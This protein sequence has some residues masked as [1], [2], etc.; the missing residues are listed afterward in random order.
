MRYAIFAYCLLPTAY[1]LLP[2]AYC[3]L[4][5]AYRLLLT[6][7]LAHHR[8]ASRAVELEAGHELVVRHRA[9]RVFQ[10]EARQAKQLHRR[11][12]LHRD[13]F[14]RADVERAVGAGLTFEVGTADRR[15]SPLGADS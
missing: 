15:P 4:P 3:L 6:G 11:R 12:D 13:R 5:T 8:R 2:T 7:P 9:V 10:L 14:R 1:C